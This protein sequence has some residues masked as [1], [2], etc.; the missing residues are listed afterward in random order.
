MAGGANIGDVFLRVLADM[1]G[2]EAD[3]TTKAGAAADK[4]GKAAGQN[5]GSRMTKATTAAFTA[6]GAAAG[7]VFTGAIGGAANFEDQLR[8]INT[9]AHLTDQ[10]LDGVGKSI[11]DLSKETGKSTDDLTA[12]FYDLVSAGVPANEAISVLR[13]SA[14]FATGA[15]GT[16]AEAV[17]LVTSS[18]NAYG[19]EAKDSTRVTDI[20]AQ[21][22]ADGKVTAAQLG[23][24]IAQI[25]PIAAQSGV[26]LEEVSAGFALLTAKGVPAAQAATQ[27]RAAISALLTPNKQLNDLQA[28]TGINFAKLAREKGLVVALDQLRKA[29]KGNDDAFAKAL[30]SIEAYNFA[31]ITTGD[32]AD[33]YATELDKV[34]VAAE[35]G[36]VA[37]EQYEERM[38][39]AASQGKKFVA[40]IRATALELAGPFVDSLGGAVIALN[41]LGGGM[42]GLVNLSRLFG[43]VLG[44]TAG[45][46]ASRLGPLVKAGIAKALGK[47]AIDVATAG[48]AKIAE[49]VADGIGENVGA[50]VAKKGI[51]AKIAGALGVIAVPI[52]IGLVLAQI[53]E[54][55]IEQ[56]AKPEI[57]RLVNEAL[58]DG[59]KAGMEKA[60][61]NLQSIAHH[62]SGPYADFVL[63]QAA[64]LQRRLDEMNGL[65]ATSMDPLAGM[66]GNNLKEGRGEVTAGAKEMVAGVPGAVEDVVPDAAA[67]GGAIPTAVADGIIAKQSVVR[68]GMASLR[69][70]METELNG[71][72]QANRLVGNLVS[73]DLSR[74]LLDGRAGVRD[75][76]KNIRSS[77]EEE[78][79]QFVKAGHNIG[80]HGMEVLRDGLR[81]KDPAIRAQALRTRKV[82]E[83]GVKARTKPAGQKAGQDVATGL[84]S[85]KGAVAAAAKS[86]AVTIYESLINNIAFQKD[87]AGE[88]GGSGGG[89]KAYGGQVYG[90]QPV[91]VGEKRP[92]VFVPEV[93]GRIYPT[94]Q[95][96]LEALGAGSNT[97]V[98]LQ[99]YGLPMRAETPLE[100]ARQVRRVTTGIMSPRRRTGW[101][102]A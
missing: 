84:A 68:D 101:S 98:N 41:E 70:I 58:T 89:G 73:K 23:A 11:L 13:D 8:T 69:H 62:N 25:A 12:G 45:F 44:G 80:V 36:G 38:K 52:A 32:N 59:T 17:D 94:I 14:E 37:H 16:T 7:A 1:A 64:V 93:S 19:L 40:G 3:V 29:T 74:G 87:R 91:L 33:E 75:A 15:L 76:A 10:E 54:Q 88:R 20:F 56:Q 50:A 9:V 21:A 2:F 99:T 90:R 97:T 71:T 4:A 42:G 85:K 100:V 24:S 67:A 39:S 95:S 6:A 61:R 51:A 83:D 47:T 31:V 27:M 81:S 28:Q 60:I 65:I 72:Q 82:I 48:G 26:S 63:G 77:A 49:G 102:G 53:G 79:F 34:T 92:E 22:V 78:L 55:Q 30:G 43:G 57:E 86:L 5:L 18:L 96:G 66:I 35:E 46:L